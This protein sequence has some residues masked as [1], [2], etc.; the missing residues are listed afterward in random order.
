M[1]Q[2]SDTFGLSKIKILDHDKDIIKNIP[3]HTVILT[4]LVSRNSHSEVTFKKPTITSALKTTSLSDKKIATIKLIF[5]T[6]VS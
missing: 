5:L 6:S 2:V 3:I 4:S 1:L